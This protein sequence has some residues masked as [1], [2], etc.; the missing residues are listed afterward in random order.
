MCITDGRHDM[1]RFQQCENCVRTSWAWYVTVRSLKFVVVEISG[2]VVATYEVWSLY[3][4]PLASYDMFSVWALRD[5]ILTCD[6]ST[7]W[8]FDVWQFWGNIQ[9]C[10]SRDGIPERD[11]TYH[12]I[13]LLIYHWTIDSLPVLRN[14][15][16]LYIMDAGLRKAPCVS[17][18]YPLSVFIA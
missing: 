2:H 9:K 16:L 4:Q 8:V 5:V 15:Y 11:V 13:W 7:F 17:C 6:L 10:S 12:L 18:C 14:A 1:W 3:N